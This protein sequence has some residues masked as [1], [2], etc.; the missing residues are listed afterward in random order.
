MLKNQIMKSFKK[1]LIEVMS[2]ECGMEV[3]TGPKIIAHSV[4][5]KSSYILGPTN[6]S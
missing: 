1:S 4:N 5:D 3:I 6:I 2:V